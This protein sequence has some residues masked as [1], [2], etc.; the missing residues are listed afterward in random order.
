[1]P[2]DGPSSGGMKRDQED[3][4]LNNPSSSSH[5]TGPW[6]RAHRDPDRDRNHGR[7]RRNSHSSSSNSWRDRDERG[8]HERDR[9]WR[10]GE[11]DREPGARK[12][13]FG[14][15]DG[16][17]RDDRGSDDRRECKLLFVQIFFFLLTPL[18]FV[19]L[20]ISPLS[21]APNFFL[22]PSS[23]RV[24]GFPQAPPLLTT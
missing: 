23:P 6:P 5:R 11:R 12:R 8:G 16:R 14:D 4:E 3:V 15:H 2:G 19:F 13:S 18:F 10:E 7:D 1:M 21:P 9:G 22:S 24:T 17:G 20:H